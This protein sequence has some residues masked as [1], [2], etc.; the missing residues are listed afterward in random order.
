MCLVHQL[1]IIARFPLLVHN[2]TI[3]MHSFCLRH[4]PIN[5]KRTVTT[6][7]LKMPRMKSPSLQEETQESR[8]AL[9]LKEWDCW[10]PLPKRLKQSFSFLWCQV[11]N[12]SRQILKHHEVFSIYIH[13]HSVCFLSQAGL[14]PIAKASI[15]WKQ[16]YP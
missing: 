12:A 11:R 8:C 16:S 10:Q 5:P 4:S 13:F 9:H 7:P 1:T 3:G 14:E 2:Q 6:F 15:K